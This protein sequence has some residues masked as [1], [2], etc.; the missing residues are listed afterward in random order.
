M[1]SYVGSR[2]M[3]KR[4]F[5]L[6]AAVVWLAASAF[7]TDTTA[8]FFAEFTKGAAAG[9]ARS[10]FGLGVMYENG[11]GCETNYVEA[12]KW[13]RKAAEQGHARGQVAL[14]SMYA[15]GRGVG[16]DETEALKWYLK[17]AVQ[18]DATGQ[19]AVG[20]IY[21]L[22]RGVAT[23]QIEAIKWYRKAA[24]Q[25]DL[26]GVYNLGW[27]YSHGDAKDFAEAMKWFLKGAA[28]GEAIC[29]HNVGAMYYEGQGVGKNPVEAYAWLAL[30]GQG[31]YPP[32]DEL[33]KT[34]EAEMSRVQIDAARTRSEALAKILLFS[35][36]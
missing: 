2:L 20:S 11:Q 36:H 22:G 27:T 18:G 1:S 8:E 19:L 26:T 17:A 24:D 7:A 16:K 13:F 35:K 14:G 10:Q 21:S 29:Q 28:Q 30:V 15:H 12:I 25:G 33:R 34:L 9:D 32:T 4:L 6:F 3:S 5:P 23:N 31:K